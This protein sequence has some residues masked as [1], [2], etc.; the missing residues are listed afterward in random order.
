MATKSTP[1]PLALG[2]HL[3]SP[4]F[5]M[6]SDARLWSFLS[7]LLFLVSNFKYFSLSWHRRKGSR[8]RWKSGCRSLRER[9]PLR[10]GCAGIRGGKI[11]WR[12]LWLGNHC[13]PFFILIVAGISTDILQQ[14]S[15][16]VSRILGTALAGGIG[17]IWGCGRNFRHPQA[18]V[19]WRCVMWRVLGFCHKVMDP[20][21]TLFSLF[22]SFLCLWW[23]F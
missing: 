1:L 13:S 12:H 19:S 16:T 9:H 20:P 8:D 23:Y 17:H 6:V 3:S 15:T 5:L 2:I 11:P 22:L 21:L 18:R 7:F 10:S 4:R 14:G